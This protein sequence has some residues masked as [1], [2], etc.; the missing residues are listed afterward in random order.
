MDTGQPREARGRRRGE[1]YA[2]GEKAVVEGIKHVIRLMHI[3][4]RIVCTVLYL[5]VHLSTPLA[6]YLSVYLSIPLTVYLTICLYL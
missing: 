4:W 1:K 6:V 3:P 5:S 2:Q